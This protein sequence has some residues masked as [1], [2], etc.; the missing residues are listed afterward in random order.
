M[1]YSWQCINNEY[2]YFDRSNGKLAKNTTVDGLKADQNGKAVKTTYSVEKIKTFI[3]A[4]NIVL[5]ITKPSDSVEDKKLK[6][7]K[8]VKTHPYNQYRLVGASM[9]SPGWEML[10]ANDI[11]DKGAGCCSS[12]SYAFAFLAV[13]TGCKSVYV[14]DDGVSKGSHAWVTMEGTNRVY[15]II[16][17]KSKS[18]S[19]NYNAGVSDYRSR[20]PRKTYV[21]G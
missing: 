16:F 4:R 12:T 19:G 11:F 17:A 15:D 2:Y 9:K 20:P 1:Q 8:W 5:E 6:C 14:C 7:F 21:G 10:F 18:F 13:E 3:K